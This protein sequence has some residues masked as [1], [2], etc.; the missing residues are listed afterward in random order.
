[1]SSTTTRRYNVDNKIEFTFGDYSGS[2]LSNKI[3]K[4]HLI[5]QKLMM[6]N[7]ILL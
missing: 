4:L 7:L 6:Y 1:M 2:L 5:N 3:I